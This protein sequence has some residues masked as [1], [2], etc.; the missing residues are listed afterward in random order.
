MGTP[1]F[2]GPVIFFLLM[3]TPFFFE[4]TEYFNKTVSSILFVAVVFIVCVF[5][6][7]ITL[8]PYIDFFL[9]KVELA[10]NTSFF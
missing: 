1:F 5:L 10:S 8:T 9:S 7:Q 3:R 6:E 4:P 2:F